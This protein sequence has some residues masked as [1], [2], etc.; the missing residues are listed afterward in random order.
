MLPWVSN[1]GRKDRRDLD[2][3]LSCCLKSHLMLAMIRAQRTERGM[4]LIQF[5][6]TGLALLDNRKAPGRRQPD[7]DDSGSTQLMIEEL[8]SPKV[9]NAAFLGVCPFSSPHQITPATRVAACLWVAPGTA[10]GES[11][12]PT[13]EGWAQSRGAHI[14][15]NNPVAAHTELLQ[16]RCMVQHTEHCLWNGLGSRYTFSLGTQIRNLQPI[17]LSSIQPG[18]WQ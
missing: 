15:C 9:S 7:C 4:P 18:K 1:L 2:S 11:C 14:T 13:A 6:T 8:Q 17:Y 5:G 10:V 12:K 16:A 3:V